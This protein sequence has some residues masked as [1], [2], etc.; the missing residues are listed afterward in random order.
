MEISKE[1][2][3]NIANEIV[4]KSSPVGIDPKKTHIIIINKLIE[5][6]KRLDKIEAGE[7]RFKTVNLICGCKVTGEGKFI[8]ADNCKHC[9]ECQVLVELHPFGNKR[10]G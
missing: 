2:Y 6:E 3:E 8:L 5:I 4:D 9:R 1:S 7:K 10:L